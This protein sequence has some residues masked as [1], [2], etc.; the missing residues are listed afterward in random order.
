LLLIVFCGVLLIHSRR[1]LDRAS[2]SLEEKESDLYLPE[3][4]Y[5]Q[6]ISMGHDGL[7]ADLV[8]AKALTYYGSHYFQRHTFTFKYLKKLFFT[9]VQLDPRNKDA[10]MIANNTLTSVNIRDAIEI[11]ELGMTYHPDYWKFPEMIGFNYYYHLNDPYTAARYYEKAAALPGHPPYV[12]SLSGKFYQESGRYED[13]LRVLYNFYSTTEDKR[14]KQS[15]KDYIEAVKEKIRLKQ[16]RLNARVTA[17]V[18]AQTVQFRPDPD[19][20]QFQFLKPL[21]TLRLVGLRPYDIHSGNEKEK[22][23]AY[24][25]RDF[26]RLMLRGASLKIEFQRHQDGRLKQDA[27]GRFQ[28]SIIMKDNRPFQVH[29]VESGLFDWNPRYPFPVDYKEQME[30]ARRSAVE[31][32]RGI[33]G[34][35]PG[36]IELKEITRFVRRVVSL[37][38]RVYRVEEDLRNIRLHSDIDYRNTFSVVIPLENAANISPTGKKDYFKSLKGK[39]IKVTGFAG[40]NDNRVVVIKVYLPSQLSVE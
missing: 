40:V 35:P 13:A 29:A 18:D 33:Y 2:V 15:F 19:N 6:F 14:L 22:L 27:R 36:E 4:P 38:F 11:L 25:Q 1:Y 16:F 26:T 34:Y 37:R 23:F 8:L 10:F 12:P 28:G 39:T 30:K 32:G 3:V 9:A 31:E 5:L 17:V 24:F 7:A 21:E 20:P